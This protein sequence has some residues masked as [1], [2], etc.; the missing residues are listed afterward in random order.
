MEDQLLALAARQV[1]FAEVYGEEA[2]RTV[3]EFQAGRLHSQQTRLIHG[4]GLRVIRDGKVGFC[5]SSNPERPDAAVAAAIETAAFGKPAD[6]QLPTTAEKAEVR[7]F[8]NRVMLVSPTRMTGWGES[9]V[10]AMR[11]RVSDL[12]LDLTFTRVYRE[13][14]IRSS[15]GLEVDY[16]RV[17]FGMSVSGLLVADGLVWF[18]EYVNLSDGNPLVIEP[19]ADRLERKAKL[20]RKKAALKTGSYPVLMMPTALPSLLAPLH[21]GVDGKAREKRTSP[22]VGRE[23]ERVVAEGL[24]IVDNPL[25]PYGLGSS[26]VDAEGVTRQRNVLFDKGVFRGF[27]FD[28][29]TAAA[30]GTETT[31][32]AQRDYT[33]PPSPGVAN[34]EVEPGGLT[35]ADAVKAIDEGVVVHGVIGGGQSNLL[36]GEV[37]L[38][39]SGAFKIEKGEPVGRVKDAMVAGNLYEMLAGVDGIGSV[40]ED[41]GSHFLPFLRFPSL[42]V[43]ARD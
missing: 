34:L 11:A 10:S 42:K 28:L 24:T 19:V 41:L 39:L 21:H 37:S 31:A 20:A 32:S 23:G 40:Q 14:R 5:S 30:C 15:A 4:Y 17:E 9:L 38:N 8:D 16:E 26:P 7:T 18:G 6:F 3:V 25:R 2:D 13:V 22:L 12:K 43:A 29:A 1:D 35:Y 27:L 33:S 36:A